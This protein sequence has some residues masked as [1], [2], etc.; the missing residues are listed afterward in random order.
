MKSVI[1][2]SILLV[3]SLHGTAAACSIQ[4][5]HET[6]IGDEKGVEGVCSNNGLPIT[7]HIANDGGVTCDGPSGSYNGYDLNALVFSACG[8]SSQEEQEKKEKKEL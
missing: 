1:I 3:L 2:V 5:R 6:Q 8:C 4:N 7:C